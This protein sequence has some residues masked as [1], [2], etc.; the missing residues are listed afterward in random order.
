M[1]PR[2]LILRHTSLHKFTLVFGADST[3][4]AKLRN[5]AGSLAGVQTDIAPSA[6]SNDAP[7]L[8][9]RSNHAN[10]FDKNTSSADTS[11]KA[12][13]GILNPPPSSNNNATFGKFYSFGYFLGDIS[14]HNGNP[15]FSESGQEWI[16]SRTGESSIFPKLSASSLPWQNDEPPSPSTPT[17][18]KPL[19]FDLPPKQMLLQYLKMFA[20]DPLS[21]IFPVV[22]PV[23]FQSVIDQ[24]Y[25][26][27]HSSPYAKASIFSFMAIAYHGPWSSCQKVDSEEYASKAQQLAPP[28]LTDPDY[29]G[30]QYYCMQSIFY[31][32]LGRL[33]QA[34]LQLT[35]ACRM[36]FMFGAHLETSRQGATDAERRTRVH[37]RQLFW[38]C[39][40][41]DKTISLRTGLPPTISDEHCD[42]S[43]PDSYA[44]FLY[45]LNP[46]ANS[47]P[48]GLSFLP[49]DLRLSIIKS[50]ISTRLYSPQAGR[51][52]DAEILRDVLEVDD[53]LERWRMSV[54]AQYRPS[55]SSG[56]FRPSEQAPN[57]TH[58]MRIMMVNF[59]YQSLLATIHRAPARCRVWENGRVGELEG[60]SS[61]QA[62][63]VEASRTCLKYLRA[64][65]DLLVGPV[66]W[67]VLY[68]PMTAILTIFC[69]VLQNPLDAR[70]EEDI[71]LLESFPELMSYLQSRQSVPR[72]LLDTTRALDFVLEAVRLCRCAINKAK[73]D[74]SGSYAPSYST[75]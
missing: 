42:L 34:T 11:Y 36:L 37:L 57:G 17:P 14:S 31:I 33:P 69:N 28:T 51:K 8:R 30:L 48:S 49:G 67:I 52:N 6:L 16:R 45:T 29:F 46:Y 63:S 73:A 64:V 61:S 24:V 66:F 25:D 1:R 15:F 53:E 21:R 38:I 62:L 27:G 47:D 3:N 20:L 5:L 10:V 68:Y 56:D 2:A 71:R 19:G 58:S 50:K 35:L 40:D 26:H 7:P 32:F 9:E 13:T 44:D 4:V 41:F 75:S 22:D 60:V 43:L 70:A 12:G 72:K 18:P 39:Y 59:G 54:P 65:S 74:L 23:L 55:I